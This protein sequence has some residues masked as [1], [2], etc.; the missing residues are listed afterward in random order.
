[1]PPE[2]MWHLGHELER[3]FELVKDRRRAGTRDDDDEPAGPMIQNEYARGR[4]RRIA[5]VA[6]NG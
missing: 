2:W 6:S 5:A 4:G 3:H 1:M